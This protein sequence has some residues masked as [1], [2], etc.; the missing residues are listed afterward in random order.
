MVERL[1]YVSL[2]NKEEEACKF[3]YVSHSNKEKESTGNQVHIS[4]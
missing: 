2:A 1:N 4:L 3:R